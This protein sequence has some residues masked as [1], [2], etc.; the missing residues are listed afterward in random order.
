MRRYL[1]S[2]LFVCLAAGSH[3]Q[4]DTSALRSLVNGDSTRG[5]ESVGRL[6]LGRTGFCTGALISERLVLT[7]AHC[8][9][10]E[11]SGERISDDQ[12]EFLAG[13]RSGRAEAY[14]GVRRTVV[15]PGYEYG[16]DVALERVAMDLALVELDMPVRNGRIVPFQTGDTPRLGESV[17]LVSYASERSEAPSIQEVC[18]VLE[19]GGG[20]AMLSCDVD[21]GASGAPIFRLGE[22]GPQI[23]SV[24][25]AKAEADG[26]EVALASAFG[27]RFETLMR[28]YSDGE[29]SADDA[30]EEALPQVRRLSSGGAETSAKFVRP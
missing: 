12:I 9:F 25:S 20:V 28:A 7:A 24:V 1:L 27:R 21:F 10:D 18:H 6:N 23:V 30:E 26:E 16:N 17:G 11:V 3:A 8:L 13:W 29:P 5:W 4:T 14:R 19:K 15:Y 22:D 2:V